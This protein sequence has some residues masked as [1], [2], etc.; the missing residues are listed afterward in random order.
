MLININTYLP[1]FQSKTS[2]MPP[3]RDKLKKEINE[4]PDKGLK[5]EL[6]KA[7]SCLARAYKDGECDKTHLNA[8][9][10]IVDNSFLIEDDFVRDKT[11]SGLQEFYKYFDITKIP[12]LALM[13]KCVNADKNTSDLDILKYFDNNEKE[14]IAKSSI[15]ANEKKF[16]NLKRYIRNYFYENPNEC[17][18]LYTTYYM[19]NLPDVHKK[20][21]KQILNKFGTYVFLENPVEAV[22]YAYILAELN[23]W[24]NAGGVFVKYP[25]MI[26]TS[27]L[28]RDFLEDNT[29]LALFNEDESISIKSDVNIKSSLRHE[30]MHCNDILFDEAYGKFDDIDFTK[31]GK[32]LKEKIW[33]RKEL[34]NADVPK[35]F[36]NYAY[37]NKRE[38]VAMAAEG[39]MSKYS[40]EFK[41]DLIKLGMP[42]WVFNLPYY[43]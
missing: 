6:L 35:D 21:C 26:D 28:N 30:I 24:D 37:N 9:K 3:R 41:K 20:L 43:K 22:S 14:K 15:Y 13:H 40:D 23:N 34:I 25:S 31:E 10:E 16:N 2:K 42:E 38:F 18:Y 11:T 4:I 7:E 36:I 17:K 1:S 19:N 39:D 33:H 5:E 8:F 32:I 12:E 29:C 27:R